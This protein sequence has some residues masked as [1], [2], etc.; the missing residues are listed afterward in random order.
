MAAYVHVF[1]TIIPRKWGLGIYDGYY[2]AVSSVFQN[3]EKW[4][5]IS[6]QT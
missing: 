2:F 6:F 5:T 3:S 4:L 1:V